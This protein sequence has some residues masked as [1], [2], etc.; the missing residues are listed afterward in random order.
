MNFP[1]G[2]E[3]LPRTDWFAGDVKPTI[4]GSYECRTGGGH[5]YNR[6]WTGTTWLSSLTQIPT[7]VQADW[8]GV[9][10]NSV[11]IKIYPISVRLLLQ[12]T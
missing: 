12:G 11:D 4:A 5:I 7:S 10:P 9:V 3:G 6:T 8:R 2:P 1:N